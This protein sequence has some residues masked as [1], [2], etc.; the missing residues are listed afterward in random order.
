M[1]NIP[2]KYEEAHE[3]ADK[4][5]EKNG[6]FSPKW[7]WDCGYKLD[8]D[9]RLL[10]ISS[11]FYPPCKHYGPGWDGIVSI[12]FID[13]E[14]SKKE[15]NCNTLDELHVQVEEYVQRTIKH[16]GSLLKNFLV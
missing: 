10:Y 3:W 14:L 5:N 8:F 2:S 11:R 16:I 13:K 4:I 12:F 1:M 15:F 7:S 9:G 6:E